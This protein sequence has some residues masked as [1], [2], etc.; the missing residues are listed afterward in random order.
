MNQT[1]NEPRV[2]HLTWDEVARRLAL[3]AAAILPVGAGAKQH[4]L[5]LPMMTDQLVVEHF[6]AVLADAWL[7]QMDVLVWPTLTYG[8]YPA[9]IAYP[10]SVSLSANVFE[11]LIGDALAALLASGARHVV[12]LD[13]GLSTRRPIE[14]AIAARPSPTAASRLGLFDSPQVL[15]AV[16]SLQRQPYGSHADEIE[17]SVM[18]ALFPGRVEMAR[19]VASPVSKGGP[20]AGPLDPTDPA[21]ENY[22]PSGSFGDPTLASVATGNALVAAIT[23]DLIA[24]VSHLS[25]GL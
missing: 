23:A 1:S 25:L 9:F 14:R 24:A 6:A 2:G 10:G 12:V 16:Q 18:L 3:G 20:Q 22:A 13:A 8:Y 11:Q 5:H 15:E 19:A 21:S 17:T 7:K 4:G